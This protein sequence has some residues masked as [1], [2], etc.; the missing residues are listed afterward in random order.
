MAIDAVKPKASNDRWVRIVL[1]GGL[2]IAF[3]AF[4]YSNVL[5]DSMADAKTYRLK[6]ERPLRWQEL[7]PTPLVLFLYEDP[8]TKDTIRGSVNSVVADRVALPELDTNGI[9]NHMIQVTESNL[10]GWKAK[11]LKDVSAG[12]LR[13]RIVRR[14]KEGRCV[15]TAFAVKG[16]TTVLISLA[17]SGSKAANLEDRHLPFFEKFLA[18]TTL[19]PNDLR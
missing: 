15:I 12:P 14:E 16:N 6:H 11:M 10:P 3:V 9:A 8:L 17:A 19:V 4:L 1:Y 7:P 18:Q 2:A 5:K 13:Y